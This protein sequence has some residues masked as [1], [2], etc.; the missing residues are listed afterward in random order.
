MFYETA[1]RDHGLP[2]DPFKA[3]VAPRPIGWISTIS[4]DGDVNL[5]PYSFFNA[6]SSRPDLVMFSS[7]GVKDSVTNIRQTGEFVANHAGW[8]LAERINLTSVPAPHGVN[9]FEI[10]GLTQA[11]CRLVRPPRVGEALAALE[12]KLVREV[13]LTDLD[14]NS[15]NA[16]MMIGQVVG[17]HIDER[18]IR[19]G[20]FDVRIA[21]PVTRLGY[22]DYDGPDGYF[23]MTRPDW[24]GVSGEGSRK[25]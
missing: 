12:C 15:A 11:P 9:E 21:K 25:S 23:E 14:G 20:K 16:F 2:H 3:I 13:E 18:A 5:A 22:R 17:V 8:H 24:A 10:A 19:D 4:A 1:T 6:I 7:E